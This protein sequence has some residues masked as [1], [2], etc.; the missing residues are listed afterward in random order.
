MLGFSLVAA[1]LA[2]APARAQFG[3]AVS[4]VGPINRS[5]GGAATAAP[6][7]AAGAIYWNPATIGG[8][9][10]SEMEFG[11]QV[12]IPRTTISSKIAPNTLGPG[13]PP[14]PFYGTTGGNNGVFPLPTFALVSNNPDSA[15]TYGIGLFE[16]GGFGVNYPASL[17]NPILM[18]QAPF[19]RGV[20]PIYTNYQIFQISPTIAV[21]L[22]DAL[23]IGFSGNADL[24]YLSATPGLFGVPT[25]V[26]T[27]LGPGL[28]Y[29]AATDGRSRLG[30]GFAAGLYYAAPD[31]DWRFGA[32]VKSPQ[33]FETYTFNSLN[34]R[35]RPDSPKL[36]LDF[37]LI[38]SVG[39]SYTGFDRW[40]IASDF[41]FLDFRDTNG[42][43]HSGF[44]PDGALRGLGWQNV[45]AFAL[46][47]Q[48]QWSDNLSLR[49]GYTFNHSPV[50]GSLTAFNLGSPTII[51]HSLALGFSYDVSRSL[52]LSFAWSHDFQHSATG[53]LIQPVIGPIPGSAVR[54]AATGDSILFGASVAF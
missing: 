2:T 44:G 28:N 17:T 34:A 8:L 22:T 46:G 6:I 14:R 47:T 4:G 19:G 1:L 35:G 16:I 24:G 5:M 50:G 54:T 15:V 43:R 26:S 27:P 39:T 30:G 10:R 52:R 3:L 36:D 49:A 53:P 25:P 42:F 33:W 7:D 21:Q 11:L 12:L 38:A 9:D 31:S 29:P 13:L 23:S 51:Q 40:L 48:Y 18:P 20:G 32:A 41:R 37:P 45:F